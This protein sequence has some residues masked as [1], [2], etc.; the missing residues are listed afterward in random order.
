[1][2][3]RNISY[4]AALDKIPLLVKAGA[5]IPMQPDMNYV[6]EKPVDPLTLDIYPS[7]TS[8][9][10]L[11]EDDGETE[12]YK[13]GAFALT[14]FVCIEREDGII[15]DIGESKGRYK[16]KLPGRA[17]ILKANQISPPNKIKIGSKTIKRY[18]SHNKFENSTCGWWHDSS[19]R[20]VWVKLPVISADDAAKVFLEGAK[21]I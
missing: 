2:G 5:I 3:P 4:A 19:K 21:S 14:T 20:I 12:D 17:Y 11:Y 9:F 8:S 10:T 15:I 18:T 1:M 6:G 7:G 16:G 13:K